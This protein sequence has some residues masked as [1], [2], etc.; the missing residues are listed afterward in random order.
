MK[1][2]E[3]GIEKEKLNEEDKKVF[4]DFEKIKLLSNLEIKQ[5]KPKEFNNAMK[6]LNAEL[7]KNRVRNKEF[8]LKKFKEHS[9]FFIGA[10]LD[11]ELIG[12]VCGFPREDYLLVS[13]IA[14]DSK[15]HNRG[16]GK[17]LI[18]EFEKNAINKKYNK[19]NVGAEDTALGFY[20]SLK[21][22]KSFLL[23]QFKKED[24]SDEVF[25]NFKI[26]K[27]YDFDNNRAI[28]VEIKKT[29]LTLLNRLRKKYPKAWFQYIFTRQLS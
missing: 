10:F 21:E 6:I 5:I 1:E 14:I 3:R 22:Y 9:E 17:R 2:L 18:K 29:D 28:E 27:K 12:I 19:I 20:K 23:I 25:N 11:D 7:G 16:F 15:F 4:S 13:E 24:Y 8:L 26:I